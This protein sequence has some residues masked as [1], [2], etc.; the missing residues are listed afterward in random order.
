MLCCDAKDVAC[1]LRWEVLWP[2]PVQAM[3]HMMMLVWR[4]RLFLEGKVFRLMCL[5]WEIKVVGDYEGEI[6]V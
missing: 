5:K 3:V 1:G 2:E 6:E 4:D